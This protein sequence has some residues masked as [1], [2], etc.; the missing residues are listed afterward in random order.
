[1]SDGNETRAPK[2]QE[3]KDN[4]TTNERRKRKR[5]FDICVQNESQR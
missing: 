4:K 1:M 3:E 2:L 5:V